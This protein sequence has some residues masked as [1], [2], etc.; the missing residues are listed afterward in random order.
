MIQQEGLL[1]S[2][3]FWDT[4]KLIRL[5]SNLLILPR[6][7]FSPR[8]KWGCDQLFQESVHILP[9]IC[10]TVFAPSSPVLILDPFGRHYLCWA[11]S[12]FPPFL[13]LYMED[14]TSQQPLLLGGAIWLGLASEMWEAMACKF[15]LDRGSKK[16]LSPSISLET[17]Q[18]TS[19][20]QMAQLWEGKAVT[21]PWPWVTVRGS[22]FKPHVSYV[23]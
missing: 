23:T 19:S 12:G 21:G 5:C 22:P 20:I 14:Y 8:E 10:P 3:H 13:D 7:F 11:I 15:L 2:S 4:L 6:A 16:L 17:E 9:A 1:K 18:A